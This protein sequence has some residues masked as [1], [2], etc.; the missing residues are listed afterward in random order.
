MTIIVIVVVLVLLFGWG[1]YGTWGRP[2]PY[3]SGVSW[4]PLG[5]ILVVILLLWALG[6][7]RG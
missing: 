7:F 3:H 1:G 2:T 5:F 4:G 6:V